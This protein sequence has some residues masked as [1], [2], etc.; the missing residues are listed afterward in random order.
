[1]LTTLPAVFDRSTVR[2]RPYG[3]APAFLS[4]K[5]KEVLYEGPAGTGKSY[6]CLWKIHAAMLK[7]PGARALIVRKTLVSLTASALVTFVQRVLTTGNY[8]VTF[9]GGSKA[10]PAQ[11]RYPNGSRIVVGG[12]DN[13]GKIMSSEYD[14]AYINEAT[15]LTE[16]DWESITTRLRFGVMP[17]Q[18][19][20]ADC[21]PAA[22]SHWLNQ[23]ANLGITTRFGSTHEDNP[24][25]WDHARGEWTE[26]G[27]SYIETL[28]RLTGVRYQRLRLGQWVAAEGQVYDAWRDELHVVKRADVADI[29]A[30]AWHFGSVDWGWSNPGVMQCWAVD[31]DGRLYLDRELYM[32]RRPVEG[33]WIPRAIALSRELD[34][35]QWVCDPSEPA[36]IAQFA[37]AGLNATSAN[38]NVLPGIGA[39][40]NRLGATGDGR[41]RLFVLE[42]CLI[43][44]DEALV[45]AKL[46]WCTTQEIPEY[47]WAKNVGG[48]TLKDKPVDAFNHGLDAMRYAVAHLDLG[49][50]VGAIDPVISA[51]FR[52]LPA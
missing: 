13:P 52:D 35:T 39:V 48:E 47:V 10:E 43:E 5:D 22:P 28:D 1:M 15:E 49:G 37:T 42:D 8:G 50:V 7:Y 3:E 33:W 36:Y 2:Y 19:L 51:G 29:L 46:P 4:C 6:A 25:L 9:F 41:V 44:R 14:I 38:I 18:Q 40:Q 31:Y 27:R 34:V 45:E 23:R 17:Y 11:F 21:N 16:N 12:M 20:I 26:R 24:T 30:Q 32:T